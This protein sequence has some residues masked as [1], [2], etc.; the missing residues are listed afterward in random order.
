MTAYLNNSNDNDFFTRC[1][2]IILERDVIIKCE[3]TK[4][5]FIDWKD[6]KYPKLGNTHESID[7]II[8]PGR[9]GL[10]EL[11]SPLKV[12]K[13]KIST[14]E[15]QASLIHAIAHIEFNA[16][17]L[18]LDAIYRF[19]HMPHEYYHNWL[20][21]AN[22][23]VYHFQLLCGHLH[24]LGFEYGSFTAHN[25]LWD[26]ALATDSDVL[27]RMALVPRVLEARGIDAM[28]ELE[29]K[30]S[31]VND[32]NLQQTLKIINHDE[33]KHVKYGDYWFK[34]ECSI[35]NLD[36]EKTFLSLLEQ[37]N[38]PKIRGAF[39]RAGRKLAGFS[40][41]ELDAIAPIST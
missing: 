3:Q 4:V 2:M 34:Y 26:M 18:A 25:G 27:L 38:A 5:L 23:E 31:I 7:K 15:G 17:N 40:D 16:I 1:K 21:V 20:E 30:L 10:P 19:Q 37:F 6:N 9:P 12:A 14:P 32:L 8:V 28:P 36:S 13:R 11:I 41:Y 24:N 29:R 35:R 22:D 39:N 33:I